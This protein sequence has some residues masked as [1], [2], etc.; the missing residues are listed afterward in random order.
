MGL[1]D[2]A[3][4][5]VK[6]TANIVT[7]PVRTAMEVTGT[8]LTTGGN[9]MNNL[10]EGNVSGA[11]GA[12]GDGVSEQVGNVKGYFQD[13][14]NGVKDIAAG[15]FEF[16]KGGVSLIG[17]PIR[18]AAR[19]AS[20]GMALA[21]GAM[22]LAGAGMT[23]LANGNLGGCDC[24]C[25]CSEGQEQYGST[26]PGYA[27]GGGQSYGAPQAYYGEQPYGPS[28][29]PMPP[30]G[31]PAAGPGPVPYGYAPAMPSGAPSGYNAYP[32]SMVSGTC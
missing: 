21:G 27:Y 23:G 2:G 5:V 1:F 15:H 3:L 25:S 31:M 10:A 30:Q 18:G 20:G 13:N 11:V 4:D 32:P 28:P 26:P 19:L 6:G 7:A 29:Y 17:A 8:T 14:I 24:Q 9:V 22:T 16:L 12:V